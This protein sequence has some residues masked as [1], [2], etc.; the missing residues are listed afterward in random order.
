MPGERRLHG[1]V[2]GLG[3]ADFADHNDVRILAH[4]RAK[5]RSERDA[6]LRVDLRLV[7]IAHVVFDRVLTVV[8]LTSGRFSMFMSA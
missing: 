6:G 1:D 7:H 2:G 5:P 4:E 3:V 8:T